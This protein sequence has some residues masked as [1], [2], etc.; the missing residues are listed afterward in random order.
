MIDGNIRFLGFREDAKQLMSLCDLVVLPS[1]RE[2]I[3][4]SLLEAM[5]NEKPVVATDV[6]G[7]REVV[8]N[9]RNGILVNTEDPKIIS[10]VT[11]DLLKDG[12]M[13]DK[14]GKAGRRK[15]LKYFDES[16]VIIR[17]VREYKHA[18]GEKIGNS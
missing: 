12:I 16:R 8:D 3:P 17:L 13:M 14:M 11:I 7:N 9:Y 6:R 2:G 15:V 4:R 1:Y 18:I 5:L 10:R